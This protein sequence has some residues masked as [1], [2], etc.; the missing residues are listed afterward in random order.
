MLDGSKSHSI[1]AEQA[2]AKM[3]VVGNEFC[4]MTEGEFWEVAHSLVV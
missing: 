1:P 2:C 4:S 3:S